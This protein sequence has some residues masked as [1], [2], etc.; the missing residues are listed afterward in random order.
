MPVRKLLSGLI[1]GMTPA[2]RFR[3]ACR[4]LERADHSVRGFARLGQ[5]A[6]SGMV[7]AQYQVAC[8][9]L[10][11]IGVPRSPLEGMRWMHRAASAGHVEAC[12]SLALMLLVDPPGQDGADSL[13]PTAWPEGI[14]AW[15]DPVAATHWAGQAARAGLPDA[16]A[17]Y[18]YLLATGPESVRDPEAAGIWCARA[19]QAGCPQGDLALAV[20]HLCAPDQPPGSNPGAVAALLRAAESGLPT[21]QYMLGLL[22]ERGWGLSPDAAEAEKWYARAAAGGVRPA[23]ARYGVMLLR[24]GRGNSRAIMAAET[25]LRRAALAGDREAAALLGDLHA[26]GKAALPGDHEAVTWYRMA[27][28]HDHAVACRMLALLYIQGRGVASDPDQ[29]RDWLQRAAV[30]GDVAAMTDLAATLLDRRD[31]PPA[32]PAQAAAPLPDFRAMAQAGDPVAAFNLAVSLHRGV[33]C[34]ADPAQAAMWMERAAEAGVVNAQYWYGR[35]LLAGEGISASPSQARHWLERAASHGL[36]E[37]CIAAAQARL[38]GYGGPRDHAGALAFYHRAAEAGRGEAMFSLGA[39]YGGGHD[40]PPDRT[41]ALHW[42]TRGAQAGNA[43][44]QF[45]LGRYL[46][47]GLAGPV[48]RAQARHWLAQAVA[49]GVTAASAELDGMML[50]D[51]HAAP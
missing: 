31:T 5:M 38:E 44:A 12:F 30:L 28:E 8:A 13:L 11:G 47:Q 32:T 2:G 21:A 7:A 35:M 29:A 20:N 23:Q 26:C 19:A 22:H 3:H 43:L 16:Q 46:A 42:F 25:W 37:A 45:M 27:A 39:M 50:A 1:G 9:Y 48:D 18:G 49:G 36:P 6:G 24:N 4:L 33:G 41:Q 17:L 10:D 15:P 40:V 34:A 14:D 51:D